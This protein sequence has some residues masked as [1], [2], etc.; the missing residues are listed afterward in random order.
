MRFYFY[1][2][3]MK[4]R[5]KIRILAFLA[6]FLVIFI[7]LF[8]DNNKKPDLETFNPIQNVATTEAIY[9]ITASLD[10]SV[11]LKDF[12]TFLEVANGLNVKITFFISEDFFNSNVETIKKVLS[13]SH[14]VGFLIEKDVAA[15]SR[16]ETM[17]YLAKLNDSFYNKCSK[18]PKYIR[19]KNGPA[20]AG[21][22]FEVLAAF[23]QY[24]IAEE[25]GTKPAT[26]MIVDIGKVDATSG[27]KLISVVTE[28]VQAKLTTVPLKDL[29][30]SVDVPA[31]ANGTQGS[32]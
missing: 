31:D 24:S 26:G 21:Y 1:N 7:L 17:R 12:R 9:S 3:R 18:Y 22:L 15:L 23:G 14:E 28:A 11:Q 27:S 25:R 8:R 4:S 13:Y 30:F 5:I 16:N 32:R 29:L 6:V 19:Y 10:S 20:K 2:F